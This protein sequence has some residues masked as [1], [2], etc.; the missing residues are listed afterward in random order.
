[1]KIKRIIL[2]LSIVLVAVFA[3]AGV[4]QAGTI[5][6]WKILAG[7]SPA[8]I[9]PSKPFEGKVDQTKQ[10]IKNAIVNVQTTGST[11]GYIRQ[12]S[13]G[14]TA[15]CDFM[16]RYKQS[17]GSFVNALSAVK[18]V[19]SNTR[20]NCGSYKNTDIQGDINGKFRLNIINPNSYNIITVGTWTPDGT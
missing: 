19:S 18:R 1:M 6:S 12:E 9:L 3:L 8:N 14:Y 15:Q 17:S 11:P 4:A 16:V 13:N 20:I 7:H 5:G 2:S 10:S